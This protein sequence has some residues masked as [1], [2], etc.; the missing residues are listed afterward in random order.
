MTTVAECKK[1]VGADLVRTKLSH[2]LN[3]SHI[4]FYI[5]NLYL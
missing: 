3:V 1:L 2:K 4:C 5:S